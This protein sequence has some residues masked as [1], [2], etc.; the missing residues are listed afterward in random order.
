MVRLFSFSLAALAVSSLFALEGRVQKSGAERIVVS[1]ETA[2]NGPAAKA[3]NRSLRRNLGISGHFR[4]GPNGQ[5]K[6]TGMPGAGVTAVGVG[7]QVKTSAAF[8]DD[9]AAR[10]AA[11]EFSDAI[12]QAHTGKKGFANDRIAFV[13]RKGKDNAELYVCYPDG[14]DIRQLT[15]DRR[16]AVGP[17]WTPNKQEIY[18]TGF[19]QQKPLVYRINPNGGQRSLLAQFSGLATGAAVAP[20]GRRYA[21][22]LSHQGNPELYVVDPGAN[23]MERMT[24]TLAASEASPCWSPNGSKIVYVTDLSRQPQIYLLD[25][26]SKKSTR[27]TNTGSQNTNPDWGP[28]GRIVYASKRGG[29]NVLVVMDPLKGES[30]AQV[31]TKPGSWEH[32]SWAS[33]GRHVIAE[34]DGALFIVDT[35]PDGDAPVQLFYN[36]GHWMNPAWSR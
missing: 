7:K 9:K 14:Y 28:D 22:V 15:A 23:R 4:V 32:P 34:R 2:D 18:Y 6:V 26:A 5:I 20:D 8:S 30:S 24:R 29:V 31:V 21:I 33:D 25:V 11:R 35:A 3:F 12:V 17:R 27:I 13:D 19:L 1:I 10:K 16:A 36:K